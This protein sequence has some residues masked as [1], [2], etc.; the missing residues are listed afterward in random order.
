LYGSDDSN[1]VAYL[2]HRGS[3][4]SFVS[5]R[6][7]PQWRRDINAGHYRYIVTSG[8]RAMWTG[9]VTPSPEMAWT[10]GDPAVER[11]SPATVSNWAL[12]IYLVRGRLNPGGCG[13]G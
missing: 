5:I 11:V 7:C 1:R 10:R 12:E 3:H 6:S 13:G 9:A 2:G 4:G 8:S